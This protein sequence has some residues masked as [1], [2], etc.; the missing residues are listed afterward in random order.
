MTS[1]IISGSVWGRIHELSKTTGL[2]FVAVPYFAS[3]AAELLKI[4]KG[5]TLILK[6]DDEAIKTGQV[7][8]REV[9]KMIE[10]GV[11]VHSYSRLHA[12]IY[13]FDESAIIGSANVSQ[14]SAKHLFEA[15]VETSDRKIIASATRCVK[16]LRG[17]E[18]GLEYARSMIASYRPPMNFRGARNISSA[19]PKFWYVRLTERPWRAEEALQ[20]KKW[21]KKALDS[22]ETRSEQNLKVFSISGGKTLDRLKVGHRVLR[23]LKTENGE[24]LVFPPARITSIDKFKE[25]IRQ[26]AIVFLE[27]P[28]GRSKTLSIFLNRL[29][30][31]E[32]AMGKATKTKPI[33]NQLLIDKI[34][35]VWV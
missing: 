7:D 2:C 11:L 9:V 25:G 33:G 26:N 8:P 30:S 21:R 28:K 13:V 14:N 5:S 27:A 22:M 19:N 3:G 6:F 16:S 32:N 10:R 18:I 31:L 17:E 15:C 1:K 20:A 34:G 24:E 23:C 12:K 29:G 35:K 4:G